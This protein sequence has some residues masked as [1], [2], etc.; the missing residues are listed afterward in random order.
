[1][2]TT[3][4]DSILQ[5]KSF[6]T[7]CV[8]SLKRRRTHRPRHTHTHTHA[9]SKCGGYVRQVRRKTILSVNQNRRIDAYS[10]VR[11]NRSGVIRSHLHARGQ[12]HKLAEARGCG[13]LGKA[14]VSLQIYSGRRS[15]RTAGGV[16]RPD[17]FYSNQSFVAPA[18]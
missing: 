14:A 2:S 17:S 7:C 15:L 5:R 4:K 3:T 18:V 16:R 12:R 8:S 10:R 6:W 9:C 13:P 11:P 1:M